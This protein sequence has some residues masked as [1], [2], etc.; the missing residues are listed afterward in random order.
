MNDKKRLDD[1][2]K[3]IRKSVYKEIKRIMLNPTINDKILNR[4]IL[5]N[6]PLYKKKKPI[7]DNRNR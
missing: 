2:L 6:L 7:P 5:K 4:H 1:K 3:Q